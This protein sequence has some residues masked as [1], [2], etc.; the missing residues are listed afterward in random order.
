MVKISIISSVV[1]VVA[2]SPVYGIFAM[3]VLIASALLVKRGLSN[4]TNLILAM[5]IWTM[6]ALS[7]ADWSISLALMIA[8]L[9][10]QDDARINVWLDMTHAV[11]ELNNV[12]ADAVL[13]WRVW[14]ISKREY[15]RILTCSVASL[16]LTT[17]SA[18]TTIGLRAMLSITL[19][20]DNTVGRSR[21]VEALSIIQI[22]TYAIS[23][24]TNVLT[25]SIIGLYLWKYR[26]FLRKKFLSNK[27]AHVGQIMVL[28]IESGL[29]YSIF[30]ISSSIC[31]LFRLQV[32]TVGDITSNI[33]AH[34]SGIYPTI[35][36]IFVSI[37]SSAST[38]TY[39]SPAEIEASS[40]H[41]N[42][43]SGDRPGSIR[44]L[45][46]NIGVSVTA[47]ISQADFQPSSSDGG[48]ASGT[49]LSSVVG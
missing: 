3:S 26:R 22:L 13:V 27:A 1:V 45:D 35:I 8:R 11:V 2:Q 20:G 28:L 30:V 21:M 10:E 37:G 34:L 31:S 5:S 24:A 44:Q 4:R 33:L 38:S 40:R 12:I 29:L 18:C 6:F 43:T 25:T 16:G 19:A 41:Q 23:F 42:R 14:V 39:P 15:P 17:A 47:E 9:K 7:T 36:I 46:S 32:G 48:I 49:M